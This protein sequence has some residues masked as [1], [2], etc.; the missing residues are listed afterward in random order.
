[1]VTQGIL[2]AIDE[3]VIDRARA[4]ELFEICASKAAS[5]FSSTFSAASSKIKVADDIKDSASLFLDVTY[6]ALSARCLVV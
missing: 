5:D 4:R 2:G 1:M 3:K 6:L